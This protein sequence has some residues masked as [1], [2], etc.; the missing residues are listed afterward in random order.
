NPPAP[1]EGAKLRWQ[2]SAVLMAQ[3]AT[4]MK[5]AQARMAGSEGAKGSAAH[6]R[7]HADREGAAMGLVEEHGALVG[8]NAVIVGGAH[9]VDRGVTVALASI[10]IAV[11][12]TNSSSDIRVE[13]R[14][15]VDQINTF[16]LDAL[17]EHLS[18]YLTSE[19]PRPTRETKNL[20]AAPPF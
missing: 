4:F 11:S 15:E 17:L 7:Q 18:P 12:R 14:V 5:N 3:M 6:C 13:R 10:N 9:G 1:T 20:K 8:K 19:S 2:A 16:V